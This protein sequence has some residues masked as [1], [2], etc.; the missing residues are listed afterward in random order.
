MTATDP[1]LRG[2]LAGVL[3]TPEADVPR[4]ICADWW[5][6]HGEPERGEFIRV[7]CELARLEASC[8]CPP[9]RTVWGAGRSESPMCPACVRAIALRRRERGLF[10]GLF[11]FDNVEQWFRKPGPVFDRYT[12]CANELGKVFTR[13][14]G[15]CIA[16]VRRGFVE[17]VSCDLATFMGIAPR[18]FA[19]Q[20][21]TRVTLTGDLDLQAVADLLN[22]PFFA[23]SELPELSDRLVA[24]GRANAEGMTHEV[25]C[26][27]CNG[28]G[29]ARVARGEPSQGCVEIRCPYCDGSGRVHHPGL[30]PLDVPTLNNPTLVEV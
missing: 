24:Y 22:L 5:E 9:L 8:A 20:P 2:L 30:P 19:S 27:R 13:V 6:E 17:S 23:R 16:L 12:L 10:R 15:I 14:T 7:Q 11:I 3:A 1:T 25:A 4:L 21:V 18:L 28:V 26:G 29:V